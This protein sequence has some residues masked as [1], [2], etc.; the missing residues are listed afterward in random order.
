MVVLEEKRRF[1]GTRQVSIIFRE[2]TV[3]VNTP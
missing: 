3:N 2:V 1:G